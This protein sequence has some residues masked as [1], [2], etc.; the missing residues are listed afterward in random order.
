MSTLKA[1]VTM[2]CLGDRSV[3][4]CS[5]SCSSQNNDRKRWSWGALLDRIARMR[6]S[7][8]IFSNAAISPGRYPWRFG[9]ESAILT[10]M[11]L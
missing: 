9:V 3:T 11:D 1:K 5:L 7:G 8:P 10:R 2:A 4:L 6:S